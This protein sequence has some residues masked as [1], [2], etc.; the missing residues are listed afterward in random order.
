M[1]GKML[2]YI[3]YNVNN[4]PNE[5]EKTAVFSSLQRQDLCKKYSKKAIHPYFPLIVY[6]ATF[7]HIIPFIYFPIKP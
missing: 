4:A 7:F 6:K 1:Q 5:K 2:C 3:I